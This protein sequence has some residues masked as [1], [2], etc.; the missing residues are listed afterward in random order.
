MYLDRNSDDPE[1]LR[2]SDDSR[3][4]AAEDRVR[5]AINALQSALEATAAI[6]SYIDRTT[7]LVWI[8]SMYGRE[9]K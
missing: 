6:P 7:T 1:V 8:A 5:M 2:V 3:V 9:I 4:I